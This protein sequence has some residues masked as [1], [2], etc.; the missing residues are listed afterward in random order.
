MQFLLQADA[1]FKSELF[2]AQTNLNNN[3]RRM[4]AFVQQVFQKCSLFIRGE[5]KTFQTKECMICPLF[6]LVAPGPKRLT[7]KRTN[8]KFRRAVHIML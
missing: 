7:R 1:N 3:C 2:P 6:I 8:P 4:F 5:L